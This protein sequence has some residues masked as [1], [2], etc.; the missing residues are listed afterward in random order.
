MPWNEADLCKVTVKST[1]TPNDSYSFDDIPVSN[2][3]VTSP[4]SVT[5]AINTIINIAG[6]SAT[7]VGA[8]R[9][10]KEEAS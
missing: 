7:S 8:V 2:G 1:S 5:A 9:V 3:S 4:E 6:F 10:L